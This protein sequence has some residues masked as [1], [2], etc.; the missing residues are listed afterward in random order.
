[1]DKAIAEFGKIDILVNNLG[2]SEPK[3]DRPPGKKD[4]MYSELYPN[5]DTLLTLDEWH[6]QIDINVTTTFLVTR[7]VGPHM[8]KQ[9]KGKVIIYSNQ[10]TK[11]MIFHLAYG[12][13]KAALNMFTRSLALEWA[14]HNI[15][16]NAIG[17]GLAYTDLGRPYVD[18]EK[19]KD[20]PC[21]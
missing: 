3:A 6:E 11:A 10:S 20:T 15:N 18:N 8:I 13:A 7:A 21:A 19:L 16:V 1:V 4:G 14:R 9:G 2:R 17:S 12:S 5:F